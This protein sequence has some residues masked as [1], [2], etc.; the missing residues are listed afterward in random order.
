MDNGV[1]SYIITNSVF[2]PFA[3]VLVTPTE[4]CPDIECYNCGNQGHMARDCEQPAPDPSPNDDLV[5]QHTDENLEEN[6]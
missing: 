6:L 2:A 4:K 5:T 3:M 1:E